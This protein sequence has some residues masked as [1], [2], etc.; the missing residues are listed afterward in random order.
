VFY[1]IC[2]RSSNS[3][4][5]TVDR[6]LPKLFTAFIKYRKSKNTTQVTTFSLCLPF[7]MIRAATDVFVPMLQILY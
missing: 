5:I 4:N 7:K 2:F 1:F 3:K 6:A